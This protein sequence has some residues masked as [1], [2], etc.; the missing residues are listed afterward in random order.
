MTA[1]DHIRSI[2]LSQR[3][4][5]AYVLHMVI[6]DSADIVIGRMHDGFPVRIDTGNYIYIGSAMGDRNGLYLPKRLV[7]HT[8]RSK[9]AK[10]QPCHA[11]LLD[12]FYEQGLCRQQLTPKTPKRLRWNIDYI[13]EY[14]NTSLR[15][16][17]YIRN[18][19]RL[20]FALVDA[21]EGLDVTVAPIPGFG[22]HDHPGHSHFLRLANGPDGWD[23]CV[24][25]GSRTVQELS[26][27]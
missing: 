11:E 8:L 24:T 25:E 14:P 12:H 27:G 16:I 4:V 1:T 13:L 9:S 6:S 21:L 5:G 23:M 3:W 7:R 19:E 17:C 15:D 26:H 10:A 20:E 18:D 2:P 22:A